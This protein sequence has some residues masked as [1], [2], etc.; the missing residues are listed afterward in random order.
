VS[1]EPIEG[2]TDIWRGSGMPAREGETVPTG[3]TGL[4]ALLPGGGWPLGAITELLDDGVES[5]SLRLL[6]P[7]LVQLSHDRRWLAWIAPPQ[8]PYAPGLAGMGLDLSRVL[9]V[10]PRPGRD[11]LWAL[12]QG[13]RAGTCSAVLAWLAGTDGAT[14]RRLQLA[15]EAGHCLGILFRPSATAA[16]PSPARLRLA[17]APTPGG[18]RIRILKR[19]GRWGTDATVNVVFEHPD[20]FAPAQAGGHGRRA[21]VS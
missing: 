8:I 18:A 4:D 2:R 16:Q 17:V 14:L 6:M 10:H 15:A 1:L 5:G 11:L 12:E 7:A 21:P 20:P 19:R 9:L 13:L 3:F